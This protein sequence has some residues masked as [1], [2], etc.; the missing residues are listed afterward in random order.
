MALRPLHGKAA[1]LAFCGCWHRSEKWLHT[2]LL[3]NLQL[4]LW[5]KPKGFVEQHKPSK[6]CCSDKSLTV[7]TDALVLQYLQ[8]IDNYSER[9]Y[10]TSQSW[11]CC[12]E[13]N[14]CISPWTYLQGGKKKKVDLGCFQPISF[15]L[16]THWELFCICLQ[17]RNNTSDPIT[18]LE[19]HRCLC[20]SHHTYLLTGKA[21]SM[22]HSLT[23]PWGRSLNCPW[24]GL[25]AFPQPPPLT[26][27]QA[28]IDGTYT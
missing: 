2:A 22:S 3:F 12:P 18:I 6:W 10:V 15:W 16:Q 14:W 4:T 17:T 1:F 19:V 5:W 9:Q 24:E 28:H 20:I 11:W 25:L 21:V 8:P 23:T 27:K 26:T 7:I 13:I